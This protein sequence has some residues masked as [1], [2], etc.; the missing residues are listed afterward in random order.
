MQ[1]N[2]NPICTLVC[3]QEKFE[4]VVVLEGTIESSGMTVQLRTSYLPSEIMWG[5]HLNPL[6]TYQKT[7]GQYKINYSQFHASSPI[8]M[9]ELSA[10]QLHE[11]AKQGDRNNCNSNGPEH[12]EYP[13]NFTAPT[14][15]VRQKRS[16]SLRRGSLRTSLRRN[17]KQ[18]NKPAGSPTTQN[19]M[20]KFITTPSSSSLY[21][22]NQGTYTSLQSVSES[23][24]AGNNADKLS[25]GSAQRSESVS[26][27]QYL[28]RSKSSP[29]HCVNMDLRDVRSADTSDTD[30]F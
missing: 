8:K 24:D 20:A 15:G 19:G 30:V 13:V 14:S 27:E 1:S 22:S 6:V 29:E 9:S 12:P 11:K 7:D 5:H 26:D 28:K 3:L 16:W 21:N 4:I 18:K 2:I 23:N 25:P 10:K 17:S